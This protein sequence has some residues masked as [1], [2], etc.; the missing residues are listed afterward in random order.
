MSFK[1]AHSQKRVLLSGHIAA[2][3]GDP[4]NQTGGVGWLE[5][6]EVKK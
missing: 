4:I 2:E 3:F 1:R 5:W 6:A